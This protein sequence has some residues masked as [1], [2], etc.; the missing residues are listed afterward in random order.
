MV[1]FLLQKGALI[2]AKDHHSHTPL[3][4][5]RQNNAKKVCNFLRKNG[6]KE[7]SPNHQRIYNVR[8]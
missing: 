4:L 5:A 1:K 7:S 6:A 2:N 3:A 8:S